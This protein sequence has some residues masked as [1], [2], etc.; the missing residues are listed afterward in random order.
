MKQNANK[1]GLLHDQSHCSQSTFVKMSEYAA[2]KNIGFLLVAI[3]AV[4]IISTNSTMPKS[5]FYFIV[6]RVL[7][8]RIA[9]AS[10]KMKRNAIAARKKR[11]II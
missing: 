1:I 10:W 3:G 5:V 4:T 2:R 11:N 6:G 7:C 9:S 8:F